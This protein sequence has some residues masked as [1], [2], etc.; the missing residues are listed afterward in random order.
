MHS[1]ASV[2]VVSAAFVLAT[3]LAIASPESRRLIE[4]GAT[5]LSAAKYDEALK[6][7]EAAAAADPNDAE[8]LFFQGVALNRLGRAPDAL[9][10]IR[11]ARAQGAK[12]GD[13]AFESGWALLGVRRWQDAVT[14]LEAYE[15]ARPGRGKTSE[16]LG[17]AYLGLKQY[18]KAEAQFREAMR[19]DPQL[20]PT[21]LL[22]L[23]ALER[24]R[25]NPDAARQ[26]IE[27]LLQ[28]ESDAPVTRAVREQIERTARAARERAPAAKPWRGAISLG[29][30][31]NNNVVALGEGVAL[32]A[33]ISRKSSAFARLTANVAYDWKLAPGDTLTAG[34]AFLGDAYEALSRYNLDDHFLS[35]DYRHVFSP[36]LL[37]GF[38]ASDEFT[39]IDGRSF[40]NELAFRPSLAYRFALR[41]A[42]EVAYS[43]AASDFRFPTLAFQDR[44]SRAQTLAVTNYFSIPATRL[45]GRFGFFHTR[46]NADG[47][48]FDFKRNGF[49]VGATLPLFSNVTADAFYLR[50]FDRYDNPNS[51]AGAAGFAFARKDD[52]D[53]VALQLGRPISTSLSLYARYDYTKYHSNIQF[54][55]FDQH[56]VSVGLIFSF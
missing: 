4:E 8:A 14:Q 10:R 27:E 26:A 17:R 36:D 19:R 21:V 52:I 2:C 23:A 33:D 41:F 6:R 30:G 42:T 39:R 38:R 9:A 45:T 18:D 40:R 11:Q 15:R 34:Y 5:S 56:V 32:P 7:F 3:S 53:R 16:F 47:S 49:L 44:D 46:N 20:R 28:Q 54:F 50:S 29:G 37:F 55:S 24:E 48:D 51:L 22:Y 43:F 35:L 12:H 1:F 31:Y 25:K 13:L